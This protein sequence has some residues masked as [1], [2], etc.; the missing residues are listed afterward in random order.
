MRPFTSVCLLS[1][2]RNF[3]RDVDEPFT[4]NRS[5]RT[6]FRAL[7]RPPPLPSSVLPSSVARQS[8]SIDPSIVNQYLLSLD[9][10]LPELPID[11]ESFAETSNLLPTHRRRP[12]TP[13]SEVNFTCLDAPILPFY[14]RCSHGNTYSEK[15]T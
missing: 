3:F 2:G 5:S 1:L 14:S 7:T 15:N 4:G 13:P 9:L 8:S 12:N 10:E 6:L 11:A